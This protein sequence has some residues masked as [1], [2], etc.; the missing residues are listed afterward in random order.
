MRV[1]I[2]THA[3]ERYVQRVD[4][5]A[6]RQEARL[7]VTQI[8]SLGRLRPVP[9]HWL[10]DHVPPSPGLLFVI[11]SERPDICLLVREN[12]VVT[13]ITRAMCAPSAAR[14]LAV[15]NCGGRRPAE[16]TAQWR[17]NG[18]IEVDEAA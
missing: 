4:G 6:S 13:I 11:W 16:E 14:H 8:A 17:W 2:S 7:A 9:R 15:V 18:M 3:V 1:A 10:R 12:V 5:N